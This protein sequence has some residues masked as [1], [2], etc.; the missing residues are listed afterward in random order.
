MGLWG[1][2]EPRDTVLADSIEDPMGAS[3]CG[4][5]TTER[6]CHV[7]GDGGVRSVWHTVDIALAVFSL[8]MFDLQSWNSFWRKHSMA[9]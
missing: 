4:A 8:C 7:L 2:S 9:V 1:V 5:V 6:R 3:A